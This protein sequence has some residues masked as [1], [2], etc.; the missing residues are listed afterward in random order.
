MS[1]HITLGSTRYKV[2]E[3]QE[4]IIAILKRVN[5]GMILLHMHGSDGTKNETKPVWFLAEAIEVV[6]T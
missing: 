2:V 3:S 4:Q 6:S 5:N 1:A